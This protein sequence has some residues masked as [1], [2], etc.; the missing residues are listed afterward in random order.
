VAT[1]ALEL[2][3]DIGNLDAVIIHGFPVTIASLRQQ[4]GR[5]GR[6]SR[7]SLAVLVADT[8]GID[9]HYVQHP[10]ELFEKVS[11]TQSRCYLLIEDI[12]C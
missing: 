11:W 9:Q 1:N 5:A 7:D 2:G 3:V 6:R 4:A 12:G 8:Y 10:E